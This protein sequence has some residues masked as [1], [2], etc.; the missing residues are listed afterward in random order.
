MVGVLQAA[1]GQVGLF[2]TAPSANTVLF[3]QIRATAAL[4]FSDEKSAID[5]A[6][7]ARTDALDAEG[8]RVINVKAQINNAK[9]AVESGQE[10]IANV[11]TKL[12]EIRTAVALAAEP[13]ED[14]E[15]R[16]ADFDG[17]VAVINGEA[18]TGGRAF[19]LVGGIDRNTFEP[20]TIEYRK[21]LGFGV[22]VLKGTYIGTDWRVEA[23]DGTVWVPDLESDTVTQ[24]SELQGQVQKTTLSDGSPFDKTS[25]LRNGVTLTSYDGTTKAIT[26][27]VTFDPEQPPEVVTGTLKQTG[28]G[29]MG[30]WF[31]DK[32]ATGVG[33]KAAFDAIE[34]AEIELTSKEAQLQLAAGTVSTDSRKADEEIARLSRSKVEVLTEQL[35]RTEKLQMTTAQQIQAMM[36]NLDNLS[37]QQ[38]NYINAFAGYV[39]SPFLR[40]NLQV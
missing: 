19:A 12:L 25:S 15:L 30:S 17:V 11:R 3:D 2:P 18:E 40:L 10:A 24:Y 9:L 14:V 1:R 33:R 37:Q 38:Q 39:H 27:E 29:L 20:N 7:K 34:K 26:F 22:S 6:A 32:L 35:T 21:N 4:R 36:V 8:D 31:Y 23:N 5:N 13:D 16:A 28:I